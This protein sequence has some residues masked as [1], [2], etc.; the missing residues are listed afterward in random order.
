VVVFIKKEKK[1]KKKNTIFNIPELKDSQISQL[2]KNWAE[3]M[4]TMERTPINC[5]RNLRFLSVDERRYLKIKD[6]IER[7]YI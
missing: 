6:N 7:F 3:L 1:E 5:S 4:E 2:R